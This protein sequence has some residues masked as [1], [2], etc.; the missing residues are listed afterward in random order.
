MTGPADPSA[1]VML[2][3]EGSGTTLT[4]IVL[5]QKF[6][7]KNRCCIDCGNGTVTCAGLPKNDRNRHHRQERKKKRDAACPEK[8]E[9]LTPVSKDNPPASSSYFRTMTTRPDFSAPE[10]W[11]DPA[12]PHNRD[13][14]VKKT[15]RVPD[16]RYNRGIQQ[17]A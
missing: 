6:L 10:C 2:I 16:H 3:G 7:K 14:F 5:G 11:Y 8:L 12:P 13:R 1:S 9:E 15:H 17:V 4:E